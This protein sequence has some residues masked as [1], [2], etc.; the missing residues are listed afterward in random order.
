MPAWQKEFFSD[1][2][3]FGHVATAGDTLK[4]SD[5]HRI[6]GPQIVVAT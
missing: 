1:V 3:G 2:P 6:N 5:G 4:T